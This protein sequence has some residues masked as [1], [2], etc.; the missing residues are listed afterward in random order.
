MR[1]AGKEMMLKAWGSEEE[2][3]EEEKEEGRGQD[4]AERNGFILITCL[5]AHT[6][7][8]VR[9][10]SCSL[11]EPSTAERLHFH[12]VVTSPFWF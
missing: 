7:G 5:G 4:E 12:R 11:L 6:A 1:T 9:K 10:Q 3:E 2:E 8:S